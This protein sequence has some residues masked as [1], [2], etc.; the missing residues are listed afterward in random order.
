MMQVLKAIVCAAIPLTACCIDAILGIKGTE[1]VVKS[2]ASVL[3][4]AGDKTVH[5]L[6]P[7]FHE[8]LVDREVAGQFYIDMQE[9][10]RLMA[11]GCLDV[12]KSELKFNICGLESS[13]L[14]NS[15]MD[16][17]QDRISTSISK[18]LQYSSVHWPNHVINGGEPSQNQQMTETIMQICKSLYPFYWM[19]V[20]SVLQEVPNGI[21]GLQD[22][23]DWLQ[24]A[25]AKKMVY[26]IRQFLLS[27]S[28]PIADSLPHIYLSA[29]P[30]SPVKSHLHQ[31][32]HEIFA[33]VLSVIRGCSAIWPEPP[34]VW[35]GHTDSVFS[36]AFSPDG[37]RIVS[38]SEDKTIQLWDANTGQPIGEPLQGHTWTV[39]SVAFSPNSQQIASGSHDNTIRLWDANT[40]QQIH[41]PL[42]G[43]TD[44]VS[45]VA[46]SLDGQKIASG[47]YDKTIRLWDAKTGQPANGPL[48][49][50]GPLQGHTWSVS[51][52]AF[53]PDGQKI[54]SG[55]HD[56]TIRLWDAKT[57]S[58]SY[59][60]FED[61]L[62]QLHS[63]PYGPHFSVPGFDDCTLSQDG[64]VK[65]S[66]KLLYWVPPSNRHGLQHPYILSIPTTG[67]H[68]A[69][70][71]DFNHFQ[72]GPDWTKCSG[73]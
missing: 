7:T 62:S 33:N 71:I 30:F 29:L 18:Q 17:L 46:F 49:A 22:V 13:F 19:E 59:N 60:K 3:S 8:F 52:V 58:L 50:G 31:E 38:G 72:C 66:N 44:S 37:Q 1:R 11:K 15:Q 69:T 48:Q 26:D 54:A 28:T 16:D 55:S 47:S 67:S 24:D 12:M 6:H 70:W 68:C 39:S 36:V 20:L 41:G 27:F 40:G 42:Q 61:I 56:K 63:N 5:L 73:K 65:S 34:Q 2:L 25:P 9:A 64:W 57:V 51:S 32:G 21:S 23:K 14:L 53:S 43:H 4:L 35:Q 10:H 45:S